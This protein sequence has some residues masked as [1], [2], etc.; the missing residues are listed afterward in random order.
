MDAP[1]PL[2]VVEAQVRLL[3]RFRR[4]DAETVRLDAAL[5]RTLAAEIIAA[6]DLPPF[7]NSAMDGYAVRAMDTAGASAA[8]PVMLA[9]I[10]SHAAGDAA[11]L[12]IREGE[13]AAIATGASLPVGADAVVRHE[14]TDGGAATVAIHGTVAPGTNVRQQGET[15]RAEAT[16]LHAGMQLTPGRIALLAATGSARPSVVRRPRIAILSTGNELIP[17]GQRAGPGQIS[18]TNGPLLAALI[19]QCGGDPLP[20][21][22]A[23]DTPD[24]LRRAFD[25]AP[26]DVDC[27]ITTGGISVG[28]YDAVRAVIAARGALNFWRVRMRPGHPVAFGAI[29]ETPLLALP[30]NPVAAFVTFHVLSRPAI[31]RMLGQMPEIPATVPVRLLHAVANRGAQQTYLRARL[32]ITRAGREADTATNQGTGNILSLNEANGLVVIPEGV[33]HVGEGAIA[34]AILLDG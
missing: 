21:G 22:I 8:Q 32:R 13:A 18:D 3:A 5:G 1:R 27:I 9:V 29:G 7:T 25:A 28:A 23:R 10:G 19:A 34:Q 24:D 17:V 30:G 14:E 20:L 31:A 2:S 12:P 11:S 4:C 33:A 26:E 6:S 16:V 15:V